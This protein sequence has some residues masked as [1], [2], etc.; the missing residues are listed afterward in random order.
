MLPH[1]FL[2]AEVGFSLMA[3]EVV[4]AFRVVGSSNSF[5]SP[6]SL[7]VSSNSESTTLCM[8]ER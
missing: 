3:L 4:F 2:G 5:S 8:V 6:S 7:K 1:A